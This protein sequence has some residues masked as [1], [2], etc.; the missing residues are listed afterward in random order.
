[1]TAVAQRLWGK[2][3]Q[4]ERIHHLLVA[5]FPSQLTDTD[6]LRYA[7]AFEI[8]L[9]AVEHALDVRELG[10]GEPGLRRVP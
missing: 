1:L 10:V 7:P 8:G 3:T 6:E 4:L 5:S 2:H 9:P